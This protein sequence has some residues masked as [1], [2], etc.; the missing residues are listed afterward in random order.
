MIFV[1]DGCQLKCVGIEV[2]TS[3]SYRSKQFF[4]FTRF[5][6]IPDDYFQMFRLCMCVNEAQNF[7]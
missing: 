2:Q 7:C 5:F 4:M 6:T 3:L 1:T